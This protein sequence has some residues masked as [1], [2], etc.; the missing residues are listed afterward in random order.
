[1]KIAIMQPYTFPYI[2]YFQLINAVD[3]FVFLDNVNFIK[4]GW[5]N[6][7]RI[8]V[9][10]NEYFFTIPCKNVSQNKLICETI[11]DWESGFFEKFFKTLQYSYKHSPYFV[12]VFEV[13]NKIFEEKPA[14]ISELAISSITE[15]CQYIKL[16][17]EFKIA[18]E[19]TN[20]RTDLKGADRL[21]DIAK[22][23]NCCTYIN[24][25]G[26]INLYSKEYFEKE[27]VKLYF[28]KTNLIENFDQNRYISFYSIIDLAMNNSPQRI[29]SYLEQYELI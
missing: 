18:S 22:K 3:K 10:S 27:S 6:R 20:Y 21:I 9:N 1:M 12:K 26:G 29:A 14:T 11:I 23:E 15:F 16:E 13:I 4:K 24:A 7:N 28:I 2:G 25:I 8:I 19:Q 5:V 17:R